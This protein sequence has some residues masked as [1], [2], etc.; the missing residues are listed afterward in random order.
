MRRP[1]PRWILPPDH[2]GSRAQALA[3]A[4]TLATLG[5]WLDVM[6]W[7]A[8]AFWCVMVAALVRYR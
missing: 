6:G 7:V 5:T 8:L 4:V 1:L 3:V 2:P